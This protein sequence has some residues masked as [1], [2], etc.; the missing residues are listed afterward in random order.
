M[1]KRKGAGWKDGT[2]Q[3]LCSCVVDDKWKCIGKKAVMENGM[4]NFRRNGWMEKRRE[5]KEIK[6]NSQI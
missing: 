4:R 5:L 3:G 2:E 6:D 1:R